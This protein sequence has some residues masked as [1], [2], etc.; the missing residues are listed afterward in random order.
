MRTAV[1]SF[2]YCIFVCLLQSAGFCTRKNLLDNFFKNVIQPLAQP[3]YSVQHIYPGPPTKI[4]SFPLKALEQLP[5]LINPWEQASYPLQPTLPS[6]LQHSL[7]IH[8]QPPS[9]LFILYNHWD[10]SQLILCRIVPPITTALLLSPSPREA[11]L[12]SATS[13]LVIFS[14]PASI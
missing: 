7:F 8:C 4:P 11:C 3:S 5:L 9:I 13:C 6:R 1:F 12:S 10:H 14:R 2:T